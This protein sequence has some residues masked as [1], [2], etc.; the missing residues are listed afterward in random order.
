M[1]KIIATILLV[2]I[3]FATFIVAI[4]IPAEKYEMKIGVIGEIALPN[5]YGN[6]GLIESLKNFRNQKC[7]VIV[8]VGKL[9]NKNQELTYPI[10]TKAVKN[11]FGKNI[12]K[13]IYAQ[14]DKDIDIQIYNN[15]FGS[16]FE[17]IET[18]YANFL[19]LPYYSTITDE[20]LEEVKI[21]LDILKQSGKPSFVVSYTPPRKTFYGSETGSEVLKNLINKYENI[22]WLSKGI[23][24]QVSNHSIYNYNS[25]Y[26]F[27]VEPLSEISTPFTPLVTKNSSARGLI[28]GIKEKQITLEKWNLSEKR[29]ESQ[30]T[31][32]NYKTT[33]NNKPVFKNKSYEFYTENNK[34]YFKFSSA[35]SEDFIYAYQFVLTYSKGYTQNMYS[36]DYFL[37][38][39]KMSDFYEIELSSSINGLISVGIK[40][41]DDN[42]NESN[43]WICD[44]N[45]RNTSTVF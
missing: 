12:P 33:I 43:L 8:I 34:S 37:G 7:D 14:S 29:L 3:L 6:Q 19:K 21:K 13:I 40:A 45:L 44:Y 35:Y 25:N 17:V 20:Y 9:T 39:H 11:I 36:T 23:Y 26:Y 31:L 16:E 22:V 4:F 1:K 5:V 2:T 18:N 15:Y 24:S 41:I 30:T 32:N 28:F 10:F 38:K 42:G 27:G